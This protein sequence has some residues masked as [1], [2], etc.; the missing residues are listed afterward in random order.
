[1]K[2]HPRVSR[3][4]VLCGL[5]ALCL[6]IPLK[7][8][9]APPRIPIILVTDINADLDDTYA[10]VQTLKDPRLDLKL[11]VTDNSNAVER[12]RLIAK[13]LTI[14]GRTD[15]PIGLG[16]KKVTFP[17][18]SQSAWLGDYQLSEYPGKI[19][20]D[21]VQAIIDTVKQSPET[22]TIVAVG[23]PQTIGDL[24]KRD[25]GIAPKVNIVL[26]NGNIGLIKDKATGEIR[27]EGNTKNDVASSRAVFAAPWKSII[28]TPMDTAALTRLEK[29][30]RS[31]YDAAETG[32]DPLL[33]ALI[34]CAKAFIEKS[35]PTLVGFNEKGDP[36]FGQ[37]LFDCAAVY[38]ADPDPKLREWVDIQPMKLKITDDGK[39]LIDPAGDEI[40]V[41]IAWKNYDAYADYLQ[42]IFLSPT[43]KP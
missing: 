26:M 38:L 10:L 12:A 32:K 2:S 36:K 31:L 22:V 25:P 19:L 28:I 15:I 3:L 24:L 1:M 30:D 34:G 6:S 4:A 8:K 21:G 23:P 17:A 37:V 41:A 9:A 27:P 20:D 5:L 43:V 35:H 18:G 40:Q 39:T 14:A 11:V 13:L 29:R 7:A 16:Q 33:A 42:S